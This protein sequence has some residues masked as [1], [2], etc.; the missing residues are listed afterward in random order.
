MNILYI[1]VEVEV[2]CALG[3]CFLSSGWGVPSTGAIACI[4]H[5]FV[6]LLCHW[7]VV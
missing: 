7:M 1:L 4:T 5:F 3:Y 6:F 2:M